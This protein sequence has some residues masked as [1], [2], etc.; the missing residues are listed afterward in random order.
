MTVAEVFAIQSYHGYILQIFA[1]E[2]LFVQVLKHRNYFYL[3]F[4]VFFVLFAFVSIVSTNLLMQVVSGLSSVTIFIWSL[5]MCYFIFQNKFKDILFCCIAAQL[6]QN[7]SHNIE[8]LIYLPLKE[9]FNDVG[10]FFLSFGVMIIVY[11]LAYFIIVRKMKQSEEINVP[12]SGSYLIALI[13][14]AF[15]YLVQFIL[16]VYQLDGYWITNLPLILCD[17]LALIV[18]FGLVSYRDKQDENLELEH[19]ITQ[20]NRYYESVKANID[21]LNMKAHDLKHFISNTRKITNV[22]DEGLKELQKTLEDYEAM[23]KTGNQTLDYVLTDKGYLCKKNH[24]PFTF[25]VDGECL[26]FMKASDL[27]S[28]FGNLLSNAIEA[29]EKLTNHNQAYILVKVVEKGQMVSI[30]IENYFT[31]KVIFKD[32]L[33]VSTKG[34]KMLHGFGSKSI[35]YIV[36]KYH[37][38]ISIQH[39]NNIYEVNILFPKQNREN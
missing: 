13:S 15:C 9:H 32:G 20:T 31:D 17:A 27:T 30:H 35:D 18:A 8:M 34:N 2:L 11:A 14:M 33:P 6:I 7:L 3:R 19:F 12:L 29:E 4:V 5:G 36:K 39:E 21:M 22:D 37:G 38:I 10:W 26:T 23:A 16:Q 1:A 24:I 25:S 28:L